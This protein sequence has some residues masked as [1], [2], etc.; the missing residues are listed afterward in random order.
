M[1]TL[2]NKSIIIFAFFTIFLYSCNSGPS[3]EEMRVLESLVANES[4]ISNID[5]LYTTYYNNFIDAF[6][7]YSE[8]KESEIL[9]NTDYYSNYS[10]WSSDKK[11]DNHN[12]Q[13]DALNQD[14]SDEQK[15][16]TMDLEE[17]AALVKEAVKK[18]FNYSP[19]DF[20]DED[21]YE[22]QR[23]KKSNIF[24]YYIDDLKE[25]FIYLQK[26]FDGNVFQDIED[27]INNKVSDPERLSLALLPLDI[28]TENSNPKSYT[29]LHY[30]IS[31]LYHIF[32]NVEYP[33]V[34]YAVKE[35][36]SKNS[37]QVGY[38]N[39][40]AYLCTFT[41]NEKGDLFYI[42]KPIEF[43]QTLIN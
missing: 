27:I 21:S 41:R 2:K 28:E 17:N 37:Y 6:N 18:L 32:K 35:A 16:L 39:L 1:K 30:R 24:N 10:I 7:E 42:T 26:F 36:D 15:L 11:I 14:N 20:D 22:L 43:D 40:D 9:Y 29:Y 33:N 13:I 23:L 5:M 8:I 34:L 3:K 25:C 31:A 19:G 12:R 4:Y 38:S